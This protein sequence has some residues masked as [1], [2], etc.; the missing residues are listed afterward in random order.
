MH[1]K[2]K[3]FLDEGHE[4]KVC[5]EA[6]YIG[7]TLKRE[8]DKEGVECEVVAPSMI[9]EKSSDKVKT[10]R[11]D[12]EKL[13][14][15]YQKGLL[16][17]VHILTEEEED[18]RRLVRSRQSLVERTK[19]LR[20]EILSHCRTYGCHYKEEREAKS[21]WTKM[22]FDYLNSLFS[23]KEVFC[24]FKKILENY[25]FVLESLNTAISD[26][27]S[28]IRRLVSTETY[29]EKVS[30]LGCMRNVS[31]LSAMTLLTE[32]GDIKRFSHPK[33]L[34]SYAGLDVIENSSGG[35]IRK[36]GITKMG[37]KRIRTCLVEMSQNCQRSY[38]IGRALKKRREGQSLKFIK[39]GDRAIKRLNK[40]ANRL[41]H[42]GK[43]VNKIKVACARELAGFV[44]EMLWSLEEVG[45]KA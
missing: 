6:T 26:L 23:K 27:E 22:H 41:L 14:L 10:D 7:T 37:N 4:L 9:P 20:R 3:K 1:Q 28:E 30:A 15:Y 38:A 31:D 35:S 19:S 13:A 16:T 32:I 2:L 18:H 33:Q 21:Y 45:L 40:K 25:L 36:G 17:P 12:S 39:I 44:W 8:F 24:V 43:P 29:K 34:M 42:R 11:R 5:Y